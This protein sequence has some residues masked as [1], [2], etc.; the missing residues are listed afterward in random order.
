MPQ[1]GLSNL[2]LRIVYFYL[3]GLWLGAVWLKIAWLLCCSILGLPIGIWM[4]HKAPLLMTLKESG[5]WREVKVG[6]KTAYIFDEM[7][8]PNFLVRAVYF[9]LIGWWFSWVWGVL[10]LLISLTFLGLPISFWMI[11]RLPWV[12]TLSRQ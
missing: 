2:I 11:N 7:P 4:V 5:E 1:S 8:S 6:S 3:I 12:T 9:L 10:A